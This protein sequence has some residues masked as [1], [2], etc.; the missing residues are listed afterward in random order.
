MSTNGISHGKTPNSARPR[1]ARNAV[2]NA[3]RD[4][5]R[6]EGR[7]RQEFSDKLTPEE[8]LKNLD[9]GQFTATKER[10]KLE[11]RIKART[12][13]VEEKQVKQ[14]VK[15]DGFTKLEAEKI[16]KKSKNAQ[17]RAGVAPKP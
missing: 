3:E 6:E 2:R 9:L 11:A 13:K 1:G 12:Q 8:R 7:V 4:R 10:A 14:L 5:R 17:G 16:V 15:A